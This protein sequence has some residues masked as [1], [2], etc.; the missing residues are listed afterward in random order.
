MGRIDPSLFAHI[1]VRIGNQNMSIQQIAEIAPKN[2]NTC[3]VNPFDHD[4]LDAIEKAIQVSDFGFQVA[5][6]E[7]TI[8]VSQLPNSM[9]ELKEKLLQKLKKTS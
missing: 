8:V 9:K 3:V 6:V 7:K 1:S 4:N 2:A 5:K